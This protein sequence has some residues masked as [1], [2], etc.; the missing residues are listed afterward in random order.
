MTFNVVF[1][2]LAFFALTVLLVGVSL[3]L[4]GPANRDSGGG[5]NNLTRVLLVCLRLAIG[6]HFAFEAADKL[7]N[8]SWSSEPYLRESVGPLAPVFRDIAGDRLVDQLD[9]GPDNTFPPALKVEWDA[10]LA[11]LSNFYELDEEQ[12]RRAGDALRQEE[13]KYV[14]WASAAKLSVELTGSTPPVV[15][16]ELT[17]PE[18]LKIHGEL[19]AVVREKEQ[20]L[21]SKGKEGLESLKSAK[22]NLAKWRAGLKKDLA[23]QN[24][25]MKKAL[26]EQL[27]GFAMEELPAEDRNKIDVKDVAKLREVVRDKYLAWERK[28]T[29]ENASSPLSPRAQKIF[30]NVLVKQKKDR[31]KSIPDPHASQDPKVKSPDLDLLDALPPS[32][33]VSKPLMEWTVLDLSD[34]F[35]KYGLLVVGL[36][37]L[38]GLLTRTACV[39]GAAYLLMFFLAMPPML[40]WPDP[41]RAEGHYLLINKNII[42]ML[43][44]LTLATTRS[45][46]W[47]GLDGLLQF[48]RPGRWRRRA[49]PV[50]LETSYREPVSV[51]S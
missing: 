49:E 35:V 36:C 19:D 9:V 26:R 42:E 50:K 43:A 10:Y 21:S 20:E 8:A 17:I 37:L 40:G 25:M 24:D 28:T 30:A 39:A 16:K 5:V 51:E 3:C 23:L 38:L 32:V 14:T 48:L 6:W 11:A 4:L 18:R 15:K 1:L 46:Y 47:A 22:D 44:L 27:V 45:G 12:Q 2:C 29:E 13:A 41:P 33:R 31:E 34:W 7:G